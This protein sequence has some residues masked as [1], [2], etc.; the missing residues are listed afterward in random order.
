[1]AG[2]FFLINNSTN[3]L[4]ISQKEKDIIES[5]CNIIFL[6][7][8]NL[9]GKFL[10]DECCRLVFGE[11]YIS[12]FRKIG[13]N[14]IK[15]EYAKTTRHEITVNDKP[16]RFRWTD[17]QL[18]LYLKMPALPVPLQPFLAQGIHLRTNSQG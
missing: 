16:A 14:Y 11:Y 3:C 6:V 18:L 10:D 7:Q 5:V 9:R 8:E 17:N 15:T 2:F 12:F 4:L 1:M 13:N